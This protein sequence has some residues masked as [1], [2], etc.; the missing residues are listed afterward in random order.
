MFGSTQIIQDNLPILRSLELIT[1]SK[2][3]LPCKPTWS[4][5]PRIRACTFWG[6]I[7]QSTIFAYVEITK[8]QEDRTAGEGTM[9]QELK[10]SRNGGMVWRFIG[11]TYNEWCGGS[12][13]MTEDSHL[14]MS[15]KKV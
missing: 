14:K 6:T 10:E 4:Q 1:S 3:F 7:I 5:G 12:N 9:G 15:G 8:D 11:N 2:T 13:M